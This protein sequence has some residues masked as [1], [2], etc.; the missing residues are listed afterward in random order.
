MDTFLSMQPPRHDNHPD[1][2]FWTTTVEDGPP[3]TR[4]Q[5]GPQGA[6]LMRGFRRSIAALAD[7]GWNVIADDVATAADWEGYRKCLGQHRLLTIKVHAPL[8]VLEERERTRGDRMAGLARDQWQRIH[9]GIAYD[10]DVDTGKLT[11]EAAAR[12]ITG[13]F[14]L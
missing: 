11:P 12:T 9:E 14:G 2:F 5:T 7:E 1:T 8:G 6:A 3:I 4:F 13:A 10:L